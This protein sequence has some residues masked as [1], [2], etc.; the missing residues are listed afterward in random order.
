MDDFDKE[1]VSKSVEE[2]YPFFVNKLTEKYKYS[3]DEA[4]ILAEYI[5]N[6]ARPVKD[7]EYAIFY[8][9]DKVNYYKRK[10]NEWKKTE[11]EFLIPKLVPLAPVRFALVKF[12]SLKL[13][14]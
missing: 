9:N 5:L 6:K 14:P 1:L 7:D 12:V 11:I 13:A 10:N 2:F 3:Q 4:P 8:D